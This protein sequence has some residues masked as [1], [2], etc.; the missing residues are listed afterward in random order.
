MVF[1]HIM[2]LLHS[3]YFLLYMELV[4]HAIFFEKFHLE[5]WMMSRMD[6]SAVS[7]SRYLAKYFLKYQKHLEAAFSS[8]DKQMPG[9]VL[10]LSCLFGWFRDLLNRQVRIL[11]LTQ[12][13]DTKWTEVRGTYTKEYGTFSAIYDSLFTSRLH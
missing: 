1:H 3:M 11:L 6:M 4:H 10:L 9:T 5:T 13:Q 7:H 2:Q 12:L 8:K